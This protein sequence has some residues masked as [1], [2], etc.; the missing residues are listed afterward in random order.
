MEQN[1]P[2]YREPN[3][4]GYCLGRRKDGQLGDSKY[5]YV[6]TPDMDFYATEETGTSPL[7]RHHSSFLGGGSVGAVGVL[8][9][10]TKNVL[11]IDLESGHYQPNAQHMVNVLT[12]LKNHGVPL[13]QVKAYP[14]VGKKDVKILGHFFLKL[15]RILKALPEKGFKKLMDSLNNLLDRTA[16]IEFFKKYD[17]NKH[18]AYLSSKILSNSKDDLRKLKM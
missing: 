1:D 12:G 8:K 17:D 16:V 15:V 7:E 5:I 14:V 11:D 6:M 3:I 13:E 10:P 18:F 9:K 4:L 2:E